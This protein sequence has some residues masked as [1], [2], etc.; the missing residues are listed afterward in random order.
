[1]NI[2]R[3]ILK[4]IEG[5]NSVDNITMLFLMKRTYDDNHDQIYVPFRSFEEIPENESYNDGFGGQEL[6]GRI[7]FSNGDI[8]IR[9][10]YDGSESWRYIQAKLEIPKDFKLEGYMYIGDETFDNSKNLNNVL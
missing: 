4:E 3:E 1:M 6:F 9:S 2:K 5:R 8:M 7:D 10:E